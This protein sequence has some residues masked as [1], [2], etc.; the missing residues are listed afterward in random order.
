VFIQ[1]DLEE[2]FNQGIIN[3]ALDAEGLEGKRLEELYPFEARPT[4]FFFNH[5]GTMK[6]G[7]GVHSISN[8]IVDCPTYRKLIFNLFL[9]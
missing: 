4:L 7:G 5:D 8:L 3:V 9:M 6:K 1:K 2:A